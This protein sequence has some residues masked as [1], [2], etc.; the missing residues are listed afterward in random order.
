MNGIIHNRMITALAAAAT[1]GFTG[2]ANSVDFIVVYDQTDPQGI[3]P[4]TANMG[5]Q[6]CPNGQPQTD[7]MVDIIEAAANHW[8]DIIEDDHTIII[9]A[10]WY[11]P[12]FGSK[13]E[14]S[15]EATD[16]QGRTTLA[17]VRI[18]PTLKYFYD[19]TPN[20]DTEFNMRPALYRT[21]H[22]NERQDAFSVAPVMSLWD[23]VEVSDVGV[24]VDND[25]GYD[26]DLYTI[27]LHEVG[28]VI[29]LSQERDQC[30]ANEPFYVTTPAQTGVQFIFDAFKFINSDDEDDTD[31]NH[32]ALGGIQ[33][34]KTAPDQATLSDEP[35]TVPGLTVQQ[36]TAHQALMWAAI[37]PQSRARPSAID[38]L[39]VAAAET[40]EEID[41]P[42]KFSQS[43]GVWQNAAQWFGPRAPDGNDEVF[44][45]N[46][47]TTIIEVNTDRNARAATISEG[48]ILE[49]SG[50]NLILSRSLRT[51]DPESEL[52][53][54]VVTPP[55]G[56]P[57]DVGNPVI[58]ATLRLS[59]NGGL[60]AFEVINHGRIEG[61]GIVG[62]TSLFSN[63]ATLRANGGT[64]RIATPEGG[65]VVINP[66]VVD[67]DGPDPFD[68]TARLIA[69]D[70]DLQ[71]D[72]ILNGSYRGRIEI[73]AGRRMSFSDGFAQLFSSQAA[74]RIVIENGTMAG[75]LT[76]SGVVE[77]EGIA[78]LE[79]QSSLGTFSRVLYEAAGQQP[80]AAADFLFVEG[81]IDL[82]GT[83]DLSLE[84]GFQP[85][86]GLV[87][88]MVRATGEITGAF[89]NYDLPDISGKGIAWNVVQ[90]DQNVLLSVIFDPSEVMSDVNGD[91]QVNIFDL[92]SIFFAAGPCP[93]EPAACPADLNGDGT[94]NLTDIAFWLAAN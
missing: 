40:W 69:R 92:L 25:E 60:Q 93:P 38:I 12:A 3:D 43:S 34:C 55:P 44:L 83:L 45:A 79:G 42:R 85:G 80:G 41:F 86:L 77:L 94:V 32:L 24:F 30:N 11:N 23:G 35:S 67:L 81:D 61:A 91:G 28:H 10:S 9:L 73:G 75:S 58:P 63:L 68:Y 5:F 18:G 70:G 72:A 22:P 64:L 20:D 88:S 7:Q 37:Y 13:P 46:A 71:I 47:T 2:P 65:G 74:K 33:A 29:G 78:T 49:V 90:N 62:V 50:A 14:A 16:A 84:D 52:G 1:L 27:A 8:A 66:P 6:V 57:G 56:D 89:A 36:C 51:V 15:I 17:R 82:N 59:N 4:C 87:L 76:L 39:A 48:N 21:L 54:I 31:C 26:A 19:P 53:P